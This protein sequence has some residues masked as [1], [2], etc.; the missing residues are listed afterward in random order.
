MELKVN[1]IAIPEQIT[2]NY[3][4]L[5]AEVLQKLS[6]YETMVYTEDQIKL[7]KED[8]ANLNRLKKALNDERIRR[9]KEYM[10]P[11]STFK[12]QI[13]EIISIIDKPVAVIDK[14]IKAAEEQAK[15]EKLNAIREYFN[16]HP[17]IEDVEILRLEQIMD[18]KWLNASVPMKS[19]QEAIDSRMGQIMSDLDVVRQLPYFAFEAEQVYLD[20]LDLAKAVSEA[21]RLQAMA[22]KKAEHE[23]KMQKAQADMNEALAKLSETAK[24]TGK[25]IVNAVHEMKETKDQGRQWIGFQAF[26]SVDEAKALGAW[27]KAQG[28]KYKAI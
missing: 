11:F 6:I 19:I 22:E 9:E 24:E 12:A 27:L 17:S 16:G 20:T 3:E 18:A 14:Q 1:N 7:A 25:A 5:K 8:R 28:I 26:L 23:A 21:H 10:Q 2:F 15:A 4:E 13:A